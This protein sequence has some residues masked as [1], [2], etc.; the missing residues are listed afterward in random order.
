M[1][2][3]FINKSN[4]NITGSLGIKFLENTE[5]FTRTF[6]KVLKH[7]ARILDWLGWDL[8]EHKGESLV[9]KPLKTIII[10]YYQLVEKE[11]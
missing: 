5:K 9:T 6:M 1:K 10:R 11:K 3:F 2:L 8:I 7:I 4:N